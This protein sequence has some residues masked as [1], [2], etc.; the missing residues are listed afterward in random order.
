MQDLEDA[1]QLAERMVAIARQA[2]RK[3]TALLS[4]M[5]QPLG[6]AVGNALEVR[7][8]IDTLRGGG[9]PDFREHC[10][11]VATHMLVLGDL[12][13]DDNQG[14]GMAEGALKDT[15]AWEKFKALVRAQGG[16]VAF[17]EN[18][19]RLPRASLVE[20][21]PAPRGGTLRWI[22]ARVVGRQPSR[23]GAG[24]E[25]KGDPIDHAVGI[26]ICTRWGTS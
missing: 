26:E 25:K 9:P 7:E 18:P 20:T 6:V 12:A 19:E 21:V 8:A 10:L 4:D 17:V 2:G 16:D 1:R 22:D 3:A 15:L 11:V 5:N 14:R 24:R 13:I 23:L